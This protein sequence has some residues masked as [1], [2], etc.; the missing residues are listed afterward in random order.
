VEQVQKYFSLPSL[1]TWQE[2]EVDVGDE[3]VEYVHKYFFL[4]LPEAGF[5]WT[6]TVLHIGSLKKCQTSAG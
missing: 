2:R 6:N 3:L 1:R 4:K 5:F